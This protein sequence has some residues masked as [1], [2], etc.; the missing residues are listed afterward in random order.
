MALSLCAGVVSN[1][2]EL[3]CDVSKGVLKKL[4]IFNGE[5]ASAD[6]ADGP[7]LLAKLVAN[8][9]LSKSAGDKVFP[10]NEAQDVAD[11]SE[12][13]KEGSLG[14]GFK[15]VLL[16]GKPAYTVKIFAGADL[17]K[18]LRKFNNQTV[19]VLEYDSNNVLWGTKSGTKF[20]GYKCKLFFSGGKLATGQNVEEGVVTFTMSILSVSEYIDNSYYASISGNIE[21]V[22]ALNDVQ[23]TKVSNTT[24][25]YKI[26]LYIPTAKITDGSIYN[27][28]DDYGA[29]IA[30][31]TF[32]AGTGTNYGTPL[33]IT[34]VAVDA[35]L[36]ALTVTFDST[37]YTALGSPTTIKLS[38]PIP[39]T[40]DAADVTN[41]ELIPVLLIKP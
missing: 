15:A 24:N 26:G 38:G 2:G 40:L 19:R 17:L 8:S 5:I 41:V 36:K 18:R 31:L 13:N 33:T 28:Y 3:A 16:E 35:T 27:I 11:S 9:K 20:I 12:A 4:F 23:L 21:D 7:A 34:S 39:A 32:T 30:A 29:L 37:A 22:K 10:I 6:Y 25:V 1:T 14:L